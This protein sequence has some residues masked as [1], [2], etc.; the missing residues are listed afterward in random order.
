VTRAAWAGSQR[1]GAAVWSGDTYSNWD[2]F[3]IQI[4][5]GLNMMMSGI[6]W[7]TTDIGGFNGGKVE[8]PQFHELLIRWFQYGAFCPIMR[9]HGCRVCDST[10]GYSTVRKKDNRRG[11]PCAP[12]PILV[13]LL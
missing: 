4:V 13:F 9:M 2:Q 7:W 10:Q 11:S 12:V 6:P 1:F 8:D 5:A 3:R